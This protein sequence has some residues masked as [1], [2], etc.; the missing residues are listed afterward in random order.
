MMD[1]FMTNANKP[2]SQSLL[3]II[4]YDNIIYDNYSLIS[5]HH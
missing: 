2:N 5:Y 1:F 3:T 4:I